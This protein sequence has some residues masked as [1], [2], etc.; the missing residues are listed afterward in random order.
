[1][2]N[3]FFILKTLLVLVIGATLSLASCGKDNDF[4][5]KNS[6][7]VN[8]EHGYTNFNLDNNQYNLDNLPSEPLSDEERASILFMREEEKVARDAYINLFEKWNQ[9]VFE[10][11][12]KS[13]ATHMGA[14][15]QLIDKYDL[16][17]PVGANGVGVFVNSNLQ[18]LYD[19]LLPQGEM[20]QVEGLKVGALIEEVDIIDLQ[21]ALSTF[22]DNQDIKMVY[23]NLMK[24]SRNHL[25]SFVKN[26]KNQGITYVPQRLS[27]DEFDAIIGGDFEKGN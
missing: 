16:T 21:N 22:I 12:S 26:L 9:P 4:T 10:N 3:S 24:G 7:D 5:R 19:A 25:R 18:A 15:L 23:E 1:M 11:I 8:Q 17:D 2:K 27:Q 20:S 13:E 6:L 14:I